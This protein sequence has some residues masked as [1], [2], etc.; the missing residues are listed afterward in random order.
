MTSRDKWQISAICRPAPGGYVQTSNPKLEGGSER[1]EK[2]AITGNLETFR[3]AGTEMEMGLKLYPAFAAAGLPAP[4]MRAQRPIG[5]GPDFP[6]YHYLAA[7]LRSVLPMMEQ[8]DVASAGEV[9]IETLRERLRDE[10][11]GL[12]AVI[13]FPSAWARK[14]VEPGNRVGRPGS[15]SDFT[16]GGRGSNHKANGD[17]EGGT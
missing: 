12:G 7:S 16:T 17:Q 11:V 2:N 1:D 15:A 14:P 13:A 3:R 5:G 8:L 9:G 6:G 4:S 10:V